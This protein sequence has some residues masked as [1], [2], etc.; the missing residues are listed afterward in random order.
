MMKSPTTKTPRVTLAG[1]GPGDAE[2]ITLKAVNALNNAD[3]VLYDALVNSALLK[4]APAGARKVFTGKRGGFCRFHQDQI[5]RLLVGYALKYGHVV[6][7]KGGDPFVFGRGH[8]ELEYVRQKGIEVAVIPG[9][10]SCIAVPE[11]QGIPL[12]T[13]GVTESFQ[14]ITGT[15]RDHRVSEDIRRALTT[16]TTLVILMG[17]RNLREIVRLCIAAGKDSLP[18]AVIRNGSLT[19]E[20][21]VTG[22]PLDIPEKVEKARIGSPAVIV[23]GEVVRLREKTLQVA[24]AAQVV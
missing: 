20:Q 18:M 23:I 1:A 16:N 2:L 11:L 19:N 10:S 17:M 7:L 21:I 3:V 15:T 24:H 5:N 9:I 14:V 22:T 4:H 12:T 6:R 8:E 13:R